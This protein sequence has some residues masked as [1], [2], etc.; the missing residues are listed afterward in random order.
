LR[1][2][3]AS[4]TAFSANQFL[5]YIKNG[6]SDVPSNIILLIIWNIPPCFENV[7]NGHAL[8]T[9]ANVFLEQESAP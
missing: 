7:S 1:T 4:S 8:V 5:E 3:A 9:A 6:E 2:T